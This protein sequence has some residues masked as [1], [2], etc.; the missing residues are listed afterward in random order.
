MHAIQA[1]QLDPTQQLIV[2]H[3][4][5]VRAMACRIHTRLPKQVEV[6]D[7]ISAGVLGLIAA[8]DR[9]D[10]ERSV[11]FDTYARHRIRGAI[12]DALR[13]MDWVP[14]SV[15]R[16]HDHIEQTRTLLRNRHGRTPSRAE[17]VKAMEMTDKNFE[18]YEADSCIRTIHS[19]DVAVNDDNN[20]PLVE[21][22]AGDADIMADT[23]DDELRGQVIDAIRFLPERERTAV[24][25]YYLQETP[26]KE[27]GKT[28]GV[29]ES[30]ACQLRSQGIKRLRYRLRRLID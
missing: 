6:D 11:P 28:L 21:Q 14:R 9:Y 4:P 5:L 29:T 2:E 17:V 13:A 7:L 27:I 18:S 15:R 24:G 1:P 16:K 19:L 10:A 25:L 22:I 23:L 3:Y 8:I 12:M 26:L 20:T 30:R